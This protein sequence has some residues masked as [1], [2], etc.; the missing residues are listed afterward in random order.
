M[1]HHIYVV[2]GQGSWF[3]SQGMDALCNHLNETPGIRNATIWDHSA[4]LQ[5]VKSMQGLYMGTKI[6]IVAYS[7]GAS[8]GPRTCRI[9]GRNVDLLVGID[10]SPYYLEPVPN[11]VQ[12]AICYFNSGAIALGGARYKGRNVTN[13]P[14]T[15]MAWHLSMDWDARVWSGTMDEIKKVLS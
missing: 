8:W 6:L 3:F 14:I 7:L 4:Q 13:V 11:S 10:P 9:S 2:R 15:S 5:M 1:S 12:R